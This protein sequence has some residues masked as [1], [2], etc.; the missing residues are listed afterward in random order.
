MISFHSGRGGGNE[1]FAVASTPKKVPSKPFSGFGGLCF[2]SPAGCS[3]K[4]GV[5][6]TCVGVAGFPPTRVGFFLKAYYVE[7]VSGRVQKEEPLV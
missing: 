2:L 4:T 3:L 6:D 7:L 5:P 1:E